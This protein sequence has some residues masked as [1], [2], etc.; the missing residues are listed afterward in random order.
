M[1]RF[2]KIPL[3][4][5]QKALLIFIG[6]MLC[7]MVLP[8]VENKNPQEGILAI[9]IVLYIGLVVIQPRKEIEGKTK[10]R[11]RNKNGV[12]DRPQWMINQEIEQDR[13][14]QEKR[15]FL[16][17]NFTHIHAYGQK[18]YISPIR[19]S[20]IVL[21]YNGMAKINSVN[22]LVAKEISLDEVLSIELTVEEE[23]ITNG[24]AKQGKS[25]TKT[26]LTSMIV[27]GTVGSLI[28]PAVGVVGA[29]TASKKT[30]HKDQI[31]NSRTKVVR[32]YSLVF[33]IANEAPIVIKMGQQET[34]ANNALQQVIYLINQARELKEA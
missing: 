29:L 9:I 16:E 30:K 27:R 14:N 34:I 11:R 22:D 25:K 1:N 28:N 26:S 8:Y 31:S 23:H 12:E 32:D 15:K 24:V 13:I 17:N 20:F 21:S 7:G 5:K 10:M 33:Y 18:I 6:L 3:T 19:N 2:K 4:K